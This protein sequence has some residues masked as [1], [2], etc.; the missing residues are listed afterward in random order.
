MKLTGCGTLLDLCMFHRILDTEEAWGCY[1]QFQC[2]GA[3]AKMPCPSGLGI[4]LN[5]NMLI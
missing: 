3:D 4:L 1:V 5:V 2:Y